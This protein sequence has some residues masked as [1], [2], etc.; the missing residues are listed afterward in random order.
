MRASG[1]ESCL[2]KGPEAG[3]CL[4]CSRDLEKEEERVA[5]ALA[6][7]DRRSSHRGNG[8]DAAGPCGLQ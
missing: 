6:R 3:L 1:G 5:P 4:E 7:E 8:V 2:C